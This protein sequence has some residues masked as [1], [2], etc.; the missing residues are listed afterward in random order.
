MLKIDCEV[1]RLRE[2]LKLVCEGRDGRSLCVESRERESLQL[3]LL[4]DIARRVR[5]IW[6]L[7]ERVKT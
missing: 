2:K 3:K 1:R 5:E 4:E 6:Q 7:N